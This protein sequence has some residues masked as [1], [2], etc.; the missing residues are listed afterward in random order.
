MKNYIFKINLQS[1]PKT[2]NHMMLTIT[3]CVIFLLFTLIGASQGVGVNET[4]AIPDA[5]AILDAASTS[6]GLLTPRMTIVQ[7]NAIVSPA[8]GLLIF[9]TDNT[10]G[11]YYNAGTPGVPNWVHLFYG[12]S[13]GGWDLSGNTGTTVAT[14]FL[15]T[16]DAQDFAIFTNNVERMR[17]QSTGNVGIGTASPDNKLHLFVFTSTTGRGQ[18]VIEQSGP[19]DAFMNFGLSGSTGYA[20]GIDNSDGDKFK[21]GYHPTQMTGLDISTRFTIDATGNVGIGTSTPAEQLHVFDA[22]SSG[23]PLRV[24]R[25]AG[26]AA[27]QGTLDVI[28][29]DFGGGTGDAILQ[30]GTSRDIALRSN[31]GSGGTLILTSAGNVGIG[32]TG[33]GGQLSVVGTSGAAGSIEAHILNNTAN[34][35]SSIRIGT[36]AVAVAGGAL[37]HF[38]SSWATSGADEASATVLY[39]FGSAGM[40]ITAYHSSGGID[41]Y[42]GGNAAGNLRAT[43]TNTGNVGIGTTSPGAKLQIDYTRNTYAPGQGTQTS[44]AL[45]NPGTTL[46]GFTGLAFRN[47]GGFTMGEI[48][49]VS[50]GNPTLNTGGDLVFITKNSA[51]TIVDERV[52]ITNAGN[53]G[54]GTTSPNTVA[55]WVATNGKLLNVYEGTN[56]ARVAIQGQLGAKVDMVDLGGGVN[57]KWMQLYTD[58]G[59]TKFRSVLD[60]GSALLMDNILAMDIGSGNVG[61]GTTSPALLF[62]VESSSSR[63]ARFESTASANSTVEIDAASGFNSNLALQEAGADKWYVGNIAS[64][65]RFRLYDNTGGSEV[66]TVLAT[67]GNVGIGT[68]APFAKLQVQGDVFLVHATTTTSNS[69]AMFVWGNDLHTAGTKGSVLG[70]YSLG[71]NG[72][73]AT[74]TEA[75]GVYGVSG[76]ES[77]ANGTV[78]NA[79]G[80]KARVQD[81]LGT[82][83]N[84]YGVY[85]EDVQ[86]A[87]DYGIYQVGTDDDN[88]F[89]GNVSIG[90]TTP[91]AKLTVDGNASFIHTTATTG[92]SIAMIL[93]GNDQHTAGTK[94][95]V[96]GLYSLG[97]NGASATT[98]DAIG[99]YAIG[100]LENSATGTVTNA[101]GLKAKAQD[102]LGTVTNGYGVYI[103]DV[104]ATTGYGLYQAGAN[105][106]NYF[107]G[108]VGIGT[109]TPGGLFDVAGSLGNFTVSSD[110][111]RIDMSRPATNYIRASSVGGALDFIVNGNAASDATASLILRP[112]G[113]VEIPNGNVGIGIAPA[114]QL[115]LSLDQGRKPATGTWTTVSDERLKNIEGAYTK[116]LNEIL[117]LQPITYHY[118]NVGER[119]FADEVLNIQNV[120]FSAQE[121]KKIFPEAVG[122]DED[123]YLNFN[124]HAIL[125]AYVNAIKELKEENDALKSEILDIKVTE[126]DALKLEL[127]AVKSTLG[128][129]AKK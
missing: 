78:T 59:I 66:F 43:I 3:T 80:L 48:G 60:N 120:G 68:T 67:S 44:L 45:K 101:Y 118:K 64:D 8:T 2:L 16:T 11:Y 74:T 109:A 75:V 128:M 1:Q 12:S 65:D 127:E 82:V 10:P 89:A 46:G 17:V 100:G 72:E 81:G 53:V 20:M 73:S 22:G 90:T 112:N 99:V 35:Y 105:D 119:K 123:G 34:G 107:A 103:E 14:N 15:G 62:D 71:L 31:A 42:T 94:S 106:D 97:L 33:P 126:I 40:N 52:R 30:S 110:G 83:T 29:S 63:I 111:A 129:K 58:G 57:D 76:L 26:T 93:W 61:I 25:D 98:T 70:L 121:V 122:T 124:M 88:Y 13:A 56:D 96:Y 87:T 38:N 125:V 4:G 104:Q 79:Y 95:Y 116:G 86:A 47:S 39:G 114:G 5:S 41:F 50:T 84:G 27:T 19:G 69:T 77:S 37:H 85:I 7:R 115:E 117:Q 113:N 6:K 92:N 32:T 21:I 102:G 24:E 36:D 23:T 28:I 55:T 49:V 9:Q 91:L 18:F 51:G 108:K 54:I